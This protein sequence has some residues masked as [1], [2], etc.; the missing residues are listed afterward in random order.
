VIFDVL[1]TPTAADVTS[2]ADAKARDIIAAEETRP[3]LQTL[4]ERFNGSPPGIVHL[5]EV[6][7]NKLS[8]KGSFSVI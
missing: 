1:G 7:S 4:E 3:P 5:I 8:F 6:G 2:L